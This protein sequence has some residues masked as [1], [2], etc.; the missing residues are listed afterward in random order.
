[1]YFIHSLLFV[2][3]RQ[4]IYNACTRYQVNISFII[5]AY[6]ALSHFICLSPLLEMVV[7]DKKKNC[8][9]YTCKDFVSSSI[10]HRGK[11]SIITFYLPF[12]FL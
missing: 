4:S 8:V 2:F 9:I 6:V 7:F 12:P 3:P 5:G 10:Y 1:M 11:C